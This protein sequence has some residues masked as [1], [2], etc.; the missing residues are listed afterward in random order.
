MTTLL[1]FCPNLVGDTVM[2]TPAFRALRKGFPSARIL[3]VVKPKVAPTLAGG[4]WFDEFVGFDHRSER[5]EE[6]SAAV[7]RRLRG[8]KAD[9]A[10]LF[11]NSFRS[12][13]LAWR[14]GARRR[15]GYARG[16]RSWLLTDRLTP[17]RDGRGGFRPSP[18]VDYYREIP[19]VLGCEDDGPRLELYTTE[20]DEAAADRAWE[21]LGLNAS[22]PVVALNT[23]GAFG[24]AKS[25]PE[26]HFASLARRL[27]DESGVAVLVVC[28][29]GER[30]AARSIVAQAGR[31]GVVTLADEPLG[32][33]LTKA[34]I[35]RSALLVTTDS[36]PRHFATGFDVP[37]ITLFCPTHISWT[38]T[39][40]RKALHLHHPVPCG[41]CQRPICPE[42][43]HRCLGELD[44]DAVFRAAV[45]MLKRRDFAGERTEAV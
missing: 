37:V 41:P 17:P 26:G 9:L 8:E 1:V 18:I 35:R 36:G 11:P 13:F 10:I 29:P 34:C 43:H 31:S 12:A 24:P 3:A 7:L 21:R 23:G 22:K 33:G 4:P 2:A 20:A 5:S 19:R 27:V 14:A 16:G 15:V 30:D 44:P 28:G 39:Y 38:L 6:R 32:I 40:H 25:W 45:R 42:R